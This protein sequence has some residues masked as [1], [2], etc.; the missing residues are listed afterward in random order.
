MRHI[1]FF[2]GAQN[3]G[4]WV[5]AEKLMEAKKFMCFFRPLEAFLLTT[6]LLRNHIEMIVAAVLF[7][8]GA[9]AASSR[10]RWYLLTS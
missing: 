1:N 9:K 8:Y 5:E 10:C 7:K 4:F 2:L 3:G 6:L